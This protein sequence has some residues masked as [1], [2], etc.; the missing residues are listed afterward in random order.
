VDAVD[1]PVLLV[2][3][4][5]AGDRRNLAG[6]LRSRYGSHHRVEDYAAAVDALARL[7]ALR[8]EGAAVPL[9]LADQWMPTMTGT[10]FLSRVREVYPAA[11]R[12]LLNS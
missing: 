10:E 5:D 4:D 9:V 8:A 2:V 3:D 11:R 7:A 1:K 6:E 12:A